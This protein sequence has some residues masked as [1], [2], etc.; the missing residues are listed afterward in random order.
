VPDVAVTGVATGDTIHLLA[1][2]IDNALRYSPPR[3]PVRVSAESAA[4][5]GVLIEIVDTG[6]GMTDTDL[7]IANMRLDAGGE[8]TPENARRMGLFVV[9]RL[10]HRHGIRIR[11]SPVSPAAQG[12]TAEVYLPPSLLVGGAGFDEPAPHRMPVAA[13]APAGQQANQHAM[14]RNGSH[15]GEPAV[16]LLP[17]RNPGSSG[18]TDVPAQPPAAP[19]AEPARPRRELPEPWWENGTQHDQHDAAQPVPAPADTSAYFSSRERA[20]TGRPSQPPPMPDAAGPPEPAEMD[21]LAAQSAPPPADA[22]AGDLIYQRM[23][24]EWLVDPHELAHSADLDWKSV[25]DHGWSVAGEA[26]NVPVVS[27][28]EHGLP[29]REPGLRLV[30]GSATSDT[31]GGPSPADEAAQHRA[32]PQRPVASNGVSHRPAHRAPERNPDAI[33]ASISSHFDGVHAARSHARDTS[34][35]T[36]QGPDD[37]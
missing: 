3:A 8:V 36:N 37:E 17:R 21:T 27:H 33:R 26:E 1:E 15:A 5:A 34:L 18:I 7:R 13:T 28:T 30:P 16:S 6:L 20:E 29:V 35:E 31:P 24:S 9:G 12:I 2:L 25:W 11:L 4:D 32:D 23:L 10:A 22:S 14:Q 19:G